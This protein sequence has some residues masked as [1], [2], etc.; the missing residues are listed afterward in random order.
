MLDIVLIIFAVIAFGWLSRHF[1]ILPAGSQKQFNDYIYYVSMPALILVKLMTTKIGSEYL[2]LLLANALPIVLIVG[3]VLALH[4]LKIFSSGLAGALLISCFFGNIIFMGFPIVEMRYGPSALAD[5]A[6]ITFVTN[7]LIFT[8][9]LACIGLLSNK[10]WIKFAKEKLAKNTII[11]SCIIG[12]VVS[13]AGIQAPELLTN[14]LTFVG[15]TTSPL[16]LFSMG[17]FL[18]GQKISARYTELA[19]M[20]AFKL[21]LFPALVLVSLYAFGLRGQLA[22]VSLLEAMMPLAVTNYVIAEKFDLD[23]KLVAEAIVVTTL[24]SIPL[25]L[26][27]DLLSAGLLSA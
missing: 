12:A 22:G 11:A 13:L 7:F 18:H 27:F 26:C 3:I 24:L 6:I 19:I 21:V 1:G 10:P 5:A 14:L 8:L 16:A 20:S 23:S 17:L 15:S 25:L 9:G 2:V 4:R